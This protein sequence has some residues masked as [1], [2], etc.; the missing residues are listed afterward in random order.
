MWTGR[1]FIQWY[2]FSKKTLYLCMQR[3]GCY[4]LRVVLVVTGV[5]NYYIW[6]AKSPIVKVKFKPGPTTRLFTLTLLNEAKTS[7]VL[8]QF[9]WDTY[10]VKLYS[11]S[12]IEPSRAT[13]I[14]LS[15]QF[16]YNSK[17][18][19]YLDELFNMLVTHQPNSKFLMSK[20]ICWH[21]S[22]NYNSIHCK[23]Y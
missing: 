21:S 22:Y 9:R 11:L 18:Y 8:H 23:L 14:Y 19:P 6:T 3:R 5:L 12:N 17:N 1:A 10:K 16:C 15:L 20:M 7:A 4:T 2:S 13:Q